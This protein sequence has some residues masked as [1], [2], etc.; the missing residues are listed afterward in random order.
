MGRKSD[1]HN[2]LIKEI[3]ELGREVESYKYFQRKARESAEMAERDYQTYANCIQEREQIIARLN[4]LLKG[5]KE[6]NNDN[7]K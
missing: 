2:A 7:N 1:L 3:T 4:K 6:N 5:K